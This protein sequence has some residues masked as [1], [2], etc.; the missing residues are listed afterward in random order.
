MEENKKLKFAIIGTGNISSEHI[1]AV[2][3][4]DGAEVTY[5]YGRNESALK[6]LASKYNLSWTTDYQSILDNPAIDVVDIVLPSGLHAEF[7]IKAAQA[8]KH[9]VVEK[10]IDITLKRAREL[11]N[12]C[13]EKGVTLGVISQ[14]R[15]SDGM[16]KIYE[17]VT[18]GKLGKI[19]QG[20]AYIKWYRSMEYYDSGEW[21]GTKT[22]DGGGAFINQAIHFIDLLLSVMGPVKKVTAKTRTVNHNIEVEDIGMAMVEFANGAHGIIQASTAI[23]PGLPA[24]LEI[25]G[26][27]GTIIFEN[28]KIVFQHIEGEELFTAVSDDE[29]S[30]AADPKNLN[31][32]LFIYEFEDIISAIKQKREPKVS[33]EEAFKALQLILAIYESSNSGGPVEL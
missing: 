17:Y 19:I 23:F 3:N 13:K 15:F 32:G 9:V 30:G 12:I 25:H 28:D 24:R 21:R 18:A 20:D 10:P 11:I 31:S 7:G 1:S 6:E 2:Q 22:L 4:I 14:M 8:G 33:G 26:S 27:K 29:I 16:Q 5:I